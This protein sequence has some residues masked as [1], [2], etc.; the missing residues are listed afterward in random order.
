MAGDGSSKV[1]AK[2]QAPDNEYTDESASALVNGKL[3]IFGGFYDGYKVK[4]IFLSKMINFRS[5][6]LKIAKSPK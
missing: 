1:S 4:L 6:S 5:R 2:I 3:F